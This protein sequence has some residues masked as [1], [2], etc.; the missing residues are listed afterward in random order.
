MLRHD[1]V[2]RRAHLMVRP[3][4]CRKRTA[5]GLL[6]SPSAPTNLS[7][8]GSKAPQTRAAYSD[9]IMPGIMLTSMLCITQS[10]PTTTMNRMI[11]VNTKAAVVQLF[12][13]V[14][15]MCRK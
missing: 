3:A 4:R 2:S 14:R 10:D 15:S 7:D 13:E 12:A 5:A 8:I 11:K 1:R 9:G 6:G